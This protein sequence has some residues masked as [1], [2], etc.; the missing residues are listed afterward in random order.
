VE[1]DLLEEAD[2]PDARVVDLVCSMEFDADVPLLVDMGVIA[3]REGALEQP[4]LWMRVTIRETTRKF[5]ANAEPVLLPGRAAHHDGP[6]DH[7]GPERR[8]ADEAPRP[9]T[10]EQRLDVFSARHGRR[11]Y[12][13]TG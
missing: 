12:E 9:L 11:R 8:V 2:Q 3:M 10:V 13:R 1:H 4:H 5:D 7:R 6:Y